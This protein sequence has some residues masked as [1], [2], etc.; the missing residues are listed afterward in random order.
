VHE[1]PH[2]QITLACQTVQLAGNSPHLLT[3]KELH[4][5]IELDN[6]QQIGRFVACRLFLL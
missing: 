6:A 3:R 2:L 5:V 4:L 1:D